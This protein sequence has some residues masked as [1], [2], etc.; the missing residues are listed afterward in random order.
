MLYGNS[1]TSI[2]FLSAPFIFLSYVLT[3]ALNLKLPLPSLFTCSNTFLSLTIYPPVAKS[4]IN[5]VFSPVLIYL[6]TALL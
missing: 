3:F 1:I 4:G 6:I 2:I 5:N